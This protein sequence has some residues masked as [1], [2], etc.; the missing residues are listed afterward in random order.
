MVLHHFNKN[1][2]ASSSNRVAGSVDIMGAA[3]TVLYVVNNPSDADSRVVFV[4]K[5]NLGQKPHP[6][7][8]SLGENGC[9]CWAEAP[10]GFDW[11]TAM[12]AKID[13][14]VEE[15]V[16][17]L[18]T[19]MAENDGEVRSVLALDQAKDAGISKGALDKAKA[20]LGIRSRRIGGTNGYWVF[21][22]KDEPRKVA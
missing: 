4:Q 16:E 13:G 5:S 7:L 18:K 6:M 11:R 3:R 15:A 19:V 12:T 8:F 2:G 1:E 14:V 9:L 10:E 20:R 17:F 22:W 21:S